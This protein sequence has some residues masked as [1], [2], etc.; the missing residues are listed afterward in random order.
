MDVVSLLSF[1]GSPAWSGPAPPSPPPWPA[2]ELSCVRAVPYT[3]PCP[4]TS[5]QSLAQSWAS[6]VFDKRR[7]AVKKGGGGGGAQSPGLRAQLL[8]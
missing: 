7:G 2:G 3:S 1:P 5:A 6:D 8:P 4:Q